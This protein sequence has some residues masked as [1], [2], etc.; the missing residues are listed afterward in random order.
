MISA[1]G[2][3]PKAGA[4]GV[5]GVGRGASGDGCCDNVGA[6]AQALIDRVPPCTS[7]YMPE[8]FFLKNCRVNNDKIWTCPRFST[9]P[10]WSHCPNP[11]EIDFT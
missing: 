5:Q 10:I 2:P 8:I 4:N 7:E 6:R 9:D 11:F 3:P 1:A